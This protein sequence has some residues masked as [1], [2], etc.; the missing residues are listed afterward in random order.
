MYKPDYNWDIWDSKQCVFIIYVNMDV[1]QIIPFV[2]HKIKRKLLAQKKYHF[3][4]LPFTDAFHINMT[5][6]WQC[7]HSGILK[8]AI[9]MSDNINHKKKWAFHWNI[10]N[11]SILTFY[12]YQ[13]TAKH[14]PYESIVTKGNPKLVETFLQTRIRDWSF[15]YM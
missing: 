2:S 4:R 12:R 8:D 13:F 9:S 11:S 15:I 10:S 14:G 7:M 1:T 3:T 5:N 6:I